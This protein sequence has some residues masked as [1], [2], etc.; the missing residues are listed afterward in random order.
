M[1]Q[2]TA[3]TGT[4]LV[5]DDDPAALRFLTETLRE[6]GHT[7]RSAPTGRLAINSYL[8]APPDLVLLDVR[9]P[10]MSG[11]DLCRRMKAERA[12]ATVPILFI[13]GLTEA[14][15]KVRG[16]EAGGVDFI[17]K[18]FS[19]PE[20]RARIETHLVLGR[21][22]R[23][24]EGKNTELHESEEKY[25]T[26]VENLNVGVYRNTGGPQGRFLQANRAIA[27]MFGYDTVQEFMTVHVA[28]LYQNPEDRQRFVAILT[29]DGEC[30]DH[31]LKLIKKDGSPIW[32]AISAKVEYD[33]DGN[34]R[35]MDGIIEDITE[36]KLA[37]D[38]LGVSQALLKKTKKSLE[39]QV[40]CV[41]RLQ[42]RFIGAGDPDQLFDSL[43]LDVLKY[44]D[45]AYGFIAEVRRDEQG[46]VFLQTLAISN[47]AWDAETRAFYDSRAPSGFR[48]EKMH[49]L[50]AAPYLSRAPVIANDP[51]TDPRRCGLPPGHPALE[52]FLGLPL[53][54]G[55][56]VVGVVG[57]ANR[58]GGYEPEIVEF[59]Q[60]VTMACS[61]IIESYKGQRAR[62]RAESALQE[63]ESRL[64]AILDYSPALISTKNLD[65]VVTLANPRFNIL[66]SPSPEAIIGRNVY[67]LFP[68]DIADALWKN[69]LAAREGPVE[70]EEV[71]PH[72]D[73]SEHTYLTIKFPLTDPAGKLTGTC[74]IS[75]DITER[76]QIERELRASEQKFLRLF[77]EVSIPLCFVDKAGVLVHINHRFTSLFGYTPA[78]VPTLEAWWPRAH[79]DEIYRRWAMDTWN[80]ALQRAVAE[81][82][83]ILPIEYE[84]T[85]KD[86]RVKTILIGGVTFGEDFLATFVDVTDRKRAEKEL[87]E[88]KE[89]AE[90]ANRAKSRF[91]A[92]MSHEIRTPMNAIIGMAELLQ[93]TRLNETQA[94]YVK[95]LNRSGEALLS[96]IS[97]ILDLSK[98]EEGRLML[99]RVPFDLHQ[100]V[101]EIMEVFSLFALEKGIELAH[102]LDETVPRRVSGDPTRVRQI[103]VNLLGNALKFTPEGHV[104]L[105]VGKEDGD[106]IRFTVA[107]TGPGI[108][109]EKQAGIFE[110]FTQVDASTTRQHG[111]TGLGLNI[112]KRLVTL[113]GGEL[114]LESEPGHGSVFTFSL[115]LPRAET[116]ADDDGG[117]PGAE[118]VVETGGVDGLNILLVEDTEENRMVVQ[119]YLRNSP[120]RLTLAANGAEALDRY[121]E[122]DFDLVLMDIQM[123]VMDGYEATRRIRAREAETGR[124]PVSIIALTAHAMAEETERITAAGC[125]LHL[126]KPV[127]KKRLLAVIDQ[128]SGK[129][130]PGPSA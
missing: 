98:I 20:V 62:L 68:H 55:A 22:V 67:D 115:S 77:M 112:C 73:G 79:P 113:M 126:T 15:E 120:H 125:D 48:F 50:Y 118:S 47:I 90:E 21:T 116:D 111:G 121:G 103:L 87:Q 12:D 35:W 45:S 130:R 54:R 29:R 114:G 100:T 105:Q 5:V 14:E 44:T 36:R 110:P 127:R 11:F 86:G 58:P 56:E 57:L 6:S 33:D 102:R 43:L 93:E 17:S 4:I 83:D 18:P 129:G 69:D 24:L 124:R 19:G 106:R 2:T 60:P 96:L 10:D 91:L 9:L 8:A 52:A 71:V 49:G 66:A 42:S 46:K 84:V 78:D 37:Q 34:I 94:W 26:L 80:G 128:F 13:S 28:D 64:Q 31:E 61:Q 27:N 32:G 85:C 101:T 65:G 75:T 38:A 108:A 97:D 76:K 41:N 51:A 30:R 92:T 59:L 40:G 117:H 107:D 74:A 82:G 95:T 89:L 88:A 72:R 1:A 109:K 123:P 81:G 119:A 23:A 53:K 122:D 3:V 99:E 25:R 104:F 7:V 70:V 39:M 16:F 63:S